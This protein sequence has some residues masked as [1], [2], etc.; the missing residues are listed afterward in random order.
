MVEKRFPCCGVTVRRQ[1]GGIRSRRGDREMGNEKRALGIPRIK[2]TE[3]DTTKTDKQEMVNER[4]GG[5]EVVRE[6]ER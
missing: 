5:T 3:K 4:Q 2:E 1:R 6:R